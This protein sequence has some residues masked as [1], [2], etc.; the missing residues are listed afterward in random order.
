LKLIDVANGVL[1]KDLE[2]KI[3]RKLENKVSE[4]ELKQIKKEAEPNYLFEL[5]TTPSDTLFGSQW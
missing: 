4:S 1:K 5:Q 2:N 3:E